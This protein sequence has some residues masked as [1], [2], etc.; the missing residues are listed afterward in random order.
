LQV[1]KIASRFVCR[2][3][4]VNRIYNPWAA[5]GMLGSMSNP[6]SHEAC[7]KWRQILQRQL[8]SNLSI[9]RFCRRE[10]LALSSFFLWKRRL[11]S[12]TPTGNT[13]TTPNAALTPTRAMF[14]EA[15]PTRAADASRRQSHIELRLRGGRIL[16]LQSGFDPELLINLLRLLESLA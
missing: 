2:E 16:R 12:A 15:T 7:E 10:K 3:R 14:V 13:L 9:A 6:A 4:Y 8:A 5:G 1:R 11:R